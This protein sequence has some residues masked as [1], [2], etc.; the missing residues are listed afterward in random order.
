MEIS[1]K[2]VKDLREK[3]NAGMMDCKEALKESGGDMDKAIDH[4]RKK[5]LMTAR[6]RAGRATSEG[7]VHSYIHGN[8]K[9]GVLV[10]VNCE[11]DFVAKNDK[12]KEFVHNVAMHIAA[13]NPVCLD[14][15][16]VPPAMLEKEREI[17]KAQAENTGKPAAVLEKIVEGRIK[18]FYTEVCLLEQPY[19]KAPEKSI[20]DLLNETVAAIG[21]NINVRR[22]TRFVVGEE[23]ETSSSEE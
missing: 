19:V 18:K 6:K 2:M 13:S 8:G 17:L 4:L 16:S 22:F 12:F 1:A 14:T 7:M 9:L 21:E 11:T 5:G 20:R 23:L 3:T 15:A 10:E